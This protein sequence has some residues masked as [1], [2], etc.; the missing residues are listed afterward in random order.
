LSYRLGNDFPIGFRPYKC[1]LIKLNNPE[2]VIELLLEVVPADNPRSQT[3]AELSR[4]LGIETVVCLELPGQS[5]CTEGF[6]AD[7]IAGA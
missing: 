7:R 6:Q 1:M 5:I 4:C 2:R 3:P